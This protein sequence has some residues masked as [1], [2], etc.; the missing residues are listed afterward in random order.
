MPT[1]LASAFTS[2]CYFS[3][4]LGSLCFKIPQYH[5]L[6]TIFR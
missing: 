5:W 3:I 1:K 6:R 4:N 2:C